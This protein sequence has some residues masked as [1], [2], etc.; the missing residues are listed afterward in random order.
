[1]AGF[2][3][4]VMLGL[5]DNLTRPLGAPMRA[6]T[7]LEQQVA[8]VEKGTQMMG[9]GAALSA[10]ATLIAAPLIV[11]TNEAIK[12]ESALADV[13]KVVDFPS[14]QGLEDMKDDLLDLSER[15]P[16]SAAGFA[17]IAAAA[18]QAGIAREEI[19]RFSEDAAKMGVAFD[20]AADQAGGAMTGLRTIFGLTQDGVVSL[21][22][23]VNYLSN[24]MD[25]KA[26]NIVDI[27]NRAGGTGK[28]LG[29]TGQQ[30]AA[31]GA[32]FLAL[33]RPP[34]VAATGINAMLLKLATAEQQSK[35]FKRR[36]D[37]L[38]LSAQQVKKWMTDDAQ[39]G[40]LKFLG[41]VSRS[42]DVMGT[43][44]D[45]FGAEYADDVASLVGNLDTYRKALG[46][47][48]DETK[49]AGSMNK[50][51]AARADTTEN[52]L[53]L[54]KNT[55]QN[56]ASTIGDILL[57]TVRTVTTV[58]TGALKTFR[59]WADS[60]PRLAQT[61]VMLTGA[62]VVLL[63]VLGN[64]QIA[65]GGL[66]I[67]AA[68]MGGGL[69]LMRTQVGAAITKLVALRTAL[70]GVATMG[71]PTA[72]QVAMMGSTMGS[73]SLAATG[74]GMTLRGAAASVWAFTLSL[75][76]NPITWVVAAVVALG[77]AFVYA[78]KH[79]DSFRATVRGAFVPVLQAWE[80]LKASFSS[81][82]TAIGPVGSAI[83]GL[84]ARLGGPL[85]ALGYAVGW[86]LGFLVT[87]LVYLASSLV[88]AF[89]DILSGLLDIVTGVMNV[90][91]GLVTGDTDQMRLGVSQ[92]LGGLERIWQ[93]LFGRMLQTVVVFG[94]R[95]V[96]GV[97]AALGRALAWV[98]AQVPQWAAVGVALAQRFVSGAG[99]VLGTI[100]RVV[101]GTIGAARTWI[102]GTVGL[103]RQAGVDIIA[104]LVS[105]ITSK[106]SAAR[107]AIVGT[108]QGLLTSFKTTLHIQSPSRVFAEQGGWITAGLAQGIA[109]T[110]GRA[111]A[112]GRN[113]ALGVAAAG[114]LTLSA[115]AAPLPGVTPGG[116]IASSSAATSAPPRG[117][118]RPTIV[119][120]NLHVL[121]DDPQDF[122]AALQ[123]L[124]EQ[125]Q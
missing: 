40:L 36:L 45:L 108:A 12:L 112:A 19:V 83:S 4:Q 115:G 100:L 99:Q 43:L 64:A 98:T 87:G 101:Q 52:S 33:K 54:L 104:G 28:L 34:E 53:Q 75:L 17:Q 109:D 3:L 89:I 49:Y 119:I 15:I 51:F 90:I 107:D 78:W 6:L 114:A 65:M 27:L 73:L 124:V 118:E 11:A 96:Q 86:L 46:L 20:M 117:G 26:S 74:L 85:D 111:E 72:T 113:L 39:A 122:V 42:K 47:A 37:D 2:D 123:Q 103:W 50:E 110:A 91:V 57:P 30:V 35:V 77:A 1:M 23:S 25:A 95:F 10:G 22:D 61:V 94:L 88:T 38:G 13:K 82:G 97:G 92:I 80:Q 32:T 5:I 21:G 81:F 121:A 79:L 120:Q 58:V 93:S 56:T 102:S 7:A 9:N 71:V 66:T 44:G 70:I 14:P 60:N 18:G 55:L 59:T 29:L 125:H 31:L 67:S 116:T 69:V 24:N 76:A 84:F 106:L 105:G 48:G 68:N 63:L 62:L 8:R 41:T 16:M